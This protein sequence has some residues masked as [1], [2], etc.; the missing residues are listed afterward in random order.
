VFAC[1]H[2]L[3]TEENHEF[4]GVMQEVSCV[5]LSTLLFRF[6]FLLSSFFLCFL[7]PIVRNKTFNNE[8]TKIRHIVY[9]QIYVK[10][11]SFITIFLKTWLPSQ[12]ADN[13]LIL[14]LSKFLHRGQFGNAKTLR[15]IQAKLLTAELY[16]R[17]LRDKCYYLAY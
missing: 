7:L 11:C 13:L 1:I 17:L 14:V 9:L 2:V 8:K 5:F 4:P 16:S 6:S 15:G 12:N 10:S 3:F